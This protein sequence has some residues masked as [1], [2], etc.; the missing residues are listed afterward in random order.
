[1]S[2]WLIGAG[3]L[4]EAV[5][6]GID[7][8]DMLKLGGFDLVVLDWDLPGKP[9][10]EILRESRQR[11]DKTPIIML[12]AKSMIDDKEKGLDFGADDYL[13]KPFAMRELAARIRA[14]LRR[15]AGFHSQVLKAGEIELDLTEHRVKKAGVEIHLQPKDFALLEFLMRHPNRIF[16][17]D[18]LLA[19]VWESESEASAD[20]LRTSIKRIRRALDAKDVD[21]SAS[22]IKNIP[23]VG[24]TVRSDD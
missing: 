23:R 19:R 5:H 24:Y 10:I 18:V 11:G 9:G 16:S 3:Y 21:E 4:V 7:G 17:S 8:S 20:A 14:A 12:T 13:T 15:P 22:I 2:D 1:V 6:N